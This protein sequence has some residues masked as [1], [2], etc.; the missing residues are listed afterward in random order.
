MSKIATKALIDEKITGNGVQAITGPILNNVLNTMVDDYGTQDELS[1]LSQ[2]FIDNAISS[3]TKEDGFYIVDESGYIA[4]KLTGERLQVSDSVF[5]ELHLLRL[6]AEDGFF[7]VDAE[8]NICLKI[9]ATEFKY[10]GGKIGGGG[11]VVI[12]DTIPAPQTLVRVDYTTPSPIPDAKGTVIQGTIKVNFDGFILEK[13]A[14]AEVQGK[15]S[16]SNPKKNLTFGLFNDEGYSDEFSL[17]IGNMVPFSEFVYKANYGDA[18]QVRNVGCNRLWEQVIMS[19]ST[20]PWR[21]N[22]GVNA[23]DTGALCHVNGYPC[24]L[25]VND[26]FYGIGWWNIGK[27]RNNYDLAK[28]NQNHIQLQEQPRANLMG[29]FSETYWEVRN[30][31]TPDADFEAKVNAWFSDNAL[32]GDA[33]KTNFPNHHNV[34]NAIDYFIFIEFIYD[35]DGLDNNIMLTTWDGNEFF[36]LPYDLD[37][38]LGLSYNGAYITPY[39]SSVTET[40]IGGNALNAGTRA[41]WRKFREAFKSELTAR[42]Q[43]LKEKGI[44]TV[45][46]IDRIVSDAQ[47]RFGANNYKLEA[48]RWPQIPS[49]NLTSKMQ[50]LTWVQ[51]RLTWMD[52]YY[53]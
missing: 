3:H 46:N 28:S 24:V 53:V 5:T 18:A 52:S 45:A 39:N 29:S 40:T 2:L 7:L 42:Y 43:E 36:M 32:T 19:H 50:I 12:R 6:T 38:S 11:S 48:G 22:E 21:G 1:Q 17:R 47:K 51:N 13:Y 44:F 41:F 34:R 8:G 33:F 26:A 27:K 9:D 4:V 14:T 35:D 37:S 31:G 25:Y 49:L 10:I 15:S 23:Y 20:P 16:A 30:P